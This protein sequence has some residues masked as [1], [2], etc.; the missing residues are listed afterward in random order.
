MVKLSIVI[1]STQS[2]SKE[3]RCQGHIYTGRTS[4][5]QF[6]RLKYLSLLKSLTRSWVVHDSSQERLSSIHDFFK[7]DSKLTGKDRTRY[8]YMI[9]DGEGILFVF[10]KLRYRKKEREKKKDREQNGWSLTCVRERC[11][12]RIGWT[13]RAR[14]IDFGPRQT[15]CRSRLP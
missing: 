7:V 9:P 13:S 12:L 15:G 4:K 14:C 8:G 10:C 5:C 3:T 2:K 6:N 11:T 1:T